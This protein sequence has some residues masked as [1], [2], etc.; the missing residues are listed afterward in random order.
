MIAVMLLNLIWHSNPCW[1]ICLCTRRLSNLRF[2]GWLSLIH[3]GQ[4][5]PFK[6]F[7][8]EIARHRYQSLQWSH[9]GIMLFLSRY[10]TQHSSP[11]VCYSVHYTQ[12][13]VNCECGFTEGTMQD[14][15]FYDKDILWSEKF[16]FRN[17]EKYNAFTNKSSHRFAVSVYL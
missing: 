5:H 13:T 1:Q 15:F 4:S 6:V 16:H 12:L 2:I 7:S 3:S 17:Y 8:F 14:F 11:H 9:S 10:N